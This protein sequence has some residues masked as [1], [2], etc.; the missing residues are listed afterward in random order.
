[1][2]ADRAAIPA[3]LA[4]PAFDVARRVILEED[5][6]V[7]APDSS[8]AGTEAGHVVTYS[9]RANDIDVD[10]EAARPCLLVHSENW[11][12]YWKAY[13]VEPGGERRELPILRANG[14]IRAIPLEAG[15]HKL[16]LRFRSE[17]YELG[18]TLTGGVLAIVLLALLGAKFLGAKRQGG[19]VGAPS[20]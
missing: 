16:E 11:F 12:P 6:G 13:E 1:V 14:A 10:V 2:V 3:R 18:K 4:D 8:A 17:P 15:R 7:P 9:Y 20:S 5:P 19:E